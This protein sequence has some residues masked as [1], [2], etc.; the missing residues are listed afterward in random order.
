MALVVPAAYPVEIE[1]VEFL[2]VDP[3]KTTFLSV[4]SQ[5]H[6]C[7]LRPMEELSTAF[8]SGMSRQHDTSL[9]NSSRGRPFPEPPPEAQFQIKSRITILIVLL[10]AAILTA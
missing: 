5:P 9:T 1:V 3:L 4:C 7:L 6:N 10:A 8:P 2:G